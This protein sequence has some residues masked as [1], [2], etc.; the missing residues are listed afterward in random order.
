MLLISP[1]STS[2]HTVCLD[3]QFVCISSSLQI[4]GAAFG[5]L[6]IA[7]QAKK[8]LEPFLPQLIPKLYRYYLLISYL[9]ISAAIDRSIERERERERW[10]ELE[11][12]IEWL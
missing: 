6:G 5:F 4:Q 10:V 11:T 2:L 7:S 9:L 8:Q 1:Y 12:A 3:S